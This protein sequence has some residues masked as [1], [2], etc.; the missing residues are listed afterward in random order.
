MDGD[1]NKRYATQQQIALKNYSSPI[2]FV[3][4]KNVSIIKNMIDYNLI[5]YIGLALMALGFMLFVVSV[6]ME[7]H[8]EVKLFE[9]EKTRKK[10]IQIIKSNY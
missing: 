7:R 4:K 8:Y 3:V 2:I 10:H 6:I 5:L 1:F 9:F